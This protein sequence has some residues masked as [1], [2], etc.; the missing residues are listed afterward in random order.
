[1]YEHAVIKRSNP[2]I[3]QEDSQLTT[4]PF[5]RQGTNRGGDIS[6]LI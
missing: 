4:S 3:R 1:M 6:I 5:T 2:G